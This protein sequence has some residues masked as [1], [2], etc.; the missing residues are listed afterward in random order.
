MLPVVSSYGRAARS[1]TVTDVVDPLI[2][3]LFS[4]D[5]LRNC[6]TGFFRLTLSSFFRKNREKKRLSLQPR[7]AQKS[8]Q[9]NFARG[10][11]L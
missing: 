2:L 7:D 10:L 4:I 8:V 9:H 11:M 3:S 5:L 6:L 1:L